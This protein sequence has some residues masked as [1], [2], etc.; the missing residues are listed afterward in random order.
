[1]RFR[2]RKPQTRY[3]QE[4]TLQSELDKAVEKALDC[5]VLSDLTP[6]WNHPGVLKYTFR[7][8]TPEFEEALAEAMLP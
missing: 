3:E 5:T 1:M 7:P 6:D 8:T 2:R 4:K